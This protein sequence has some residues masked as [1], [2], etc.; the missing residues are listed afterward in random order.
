MKK[1]THAYI[2]SEIRKKI[3]LVFQDI[4]IHIGNI[5]VGEIIVRNSI[6]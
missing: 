5:Q 6:S 3:T 1:D 4:T 2:K